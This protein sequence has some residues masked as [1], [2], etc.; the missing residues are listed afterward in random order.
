MT[1]PAATLMIAGLLA[2][3]QETT[4]SA[5]QSA[6]AFQQVYGNWVLACD[7]RAFRGHRIAFDLTL[8]SSGRIVEG[9]KLVRPRDDAGWRRAA[10]SAR[11][12]LLDSS[13]FDVPA[14][15]TGGTYRPVFNTTRACASAA[16][17]DE[18]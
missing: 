16:E 9:P 12:A 3:R 18:D 15:F 8:D 1:M 7:D 13:P 4:P 5:T 11:Q 6:V 2:A 10:E 14:E 17:A